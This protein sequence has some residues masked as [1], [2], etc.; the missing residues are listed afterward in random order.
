MIKQ[1]LN[2][3][4]LIATASTLSAQNYS[5]G[6]GT[7]FD[8]YQI[9]NK[10]D[11]KYLSD[12]NGEWSKYFTQTVDISFD[13]LDFV[14]TG[15]F[16][17]VGQGF[18]P[19]GNPTTQ[20]TG[21]YDGNYHIIQNLYINRFS[22]TFVGLFGYVANSANVINLGCS[23]IN[24][25]GDNNTGGLAGG[26]DGAI[27]KC[28]STGIVN[29]LFTAGGLVGQNDGT[30]TQ[31]YSNITL[32]GS[33][34]L[35]GLAGKNNNY[36]N[37]CYS[38]GVITGND[39]I[40]GL[41]GGNN[42]DIEYCYSNCAISG[43]GLNLG[44]LIG[45]EDGNSSLSCFYNTNYYPTDNGIGTTGQD[46]IEMQ[47]QAN[48]TNVGWDFINETTNGTT[49]IWTIGAC[50]SDLSSYPIFKWQVF[51]LGGDGTIANPFVVATK[52]DLKTLSENSCLWDKH[53]IQTSDIS[54]SNADFN[55]GGDFENGMNSIGNS[56]L[57]F[58]GSYNGKG[59]TISNFYMHN[60]NRGIYGFFGD[61]Y[62]SFSIDSLNLSNVDIMGNN[63]I[64]GLVGDM[65]NGTINNCAITGTVIGKVLFGGLVGRNDGIINNCSFTGFVKSNPFSTNCFKGGGISGLNV[66]QMYNCYSLGE[67]TKSTIDS[68]TA[69]NESVT[70]Q[71]MESLGGLCGE[72]W[73]FIRNSYSQSLVRGQ[74]WT[75]GLTAYN[76]GTIYKCYATGNVSG[77]NYTGGFIG[78]NYDNSY[79]D[80]CYATG[81]VTGGDGNTNYMGGFVGSNKGD[82]QL[83][84]SSGNVNADTSD[85]VAGF[86]AEN[87]NNG[88]IKNCYTTS[89]TSG[90][91]TFKISGFLGY[92]DSNYNI[93]NCYA[94]GYIDTT[95]IPNYGGLTTD[96]S[97]VLNCFWDTISTGITTVNVNTGLP[98]A[99]M[100][101][102]NTFTAAGWDFTGETT[103]GTNDFWT[104]GNCANNNG[105]PVFT[106]QTLHPVPTV[107]VSSTN[108]LCNSGSTGSSAI[109]VNNSL[110]TPTYSW[111]PSGGS[112]A[113]ASNL[114]AGVYTCSINAGTCA[115]TQT[116]TITEPTPL[117]SSFTS[118]DEISGNDGTID[119]TVSGGTTSYTYS[120]TGPN[121]F[122]SSSEDLTGLGAGIYN[123]TITDANNCSITNQV[124]VGSQVG[125]KHITS[126]ST[127]IYPNPST[128]VF[129]IDGLEKETTLEVI[130]VIG[131]VVYTTKTNDA[132]TNI[133]LSNQANGVYYLKTN[134]GLIHKLIKQD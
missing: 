101:L 46:D 71:Y 50:N 72:N 66:G 81:N 65:R 60:N 113:T 115:F 64:G 110:V 134:S 5:G 89:R 103:N 21:S 107:S 117:T 69:V 109:T 13:S 106:W 11:L 94:V 73:G 90:S 122:T 133:D 47:T 99:Q 111:L 124:T 91:N 123:L 49:D 14:S 130:N 95:G 119:L 98:T 17:Y 4:L 38:T 1:I 23:N 75:G 68:A 34:Y 32:N 15:D 62:T 36:I 35:G 28:Y 10:A 53:F 104:M 74:D 58:S 41:V 18:S 55:L 8:P 57:T 108:V 126:A 26:N 24:I 86:A 45:N 77:T 12:H 39:N 40:G 128:G 116:V 22:Q 51:P 59:H 16:Y 29:G 54:F 33:Q 67:V 84:Y 42:G 80:T 100:Q 125:L 121:S 31:S 114:T 6:N 83:C 102:Q 132:K 2:F 82:I 27:Y 25:T 92:N 78:Q 131:Q 105:Y 85:F 43:T 127:K 63:D 7:P 48:F 129:M 87:A 120:W 97:G 79:I 93:E 76:E 96:L 20:F 37:N 3:A 70:D 30:I 112:S 19:I 118:N 52:N 9:S 56:L 88:T 44:A 61:V